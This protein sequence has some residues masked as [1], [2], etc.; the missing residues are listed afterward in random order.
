MLFGPGRARAYE[1][2][3]TYRISHPLLV[4]AGT[5]ASAFAIVFPSGRKAYLQLCFPPEKPP[6]DKFSFIF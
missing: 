4:L 2:G 1:R 6:V 5:P 3:L